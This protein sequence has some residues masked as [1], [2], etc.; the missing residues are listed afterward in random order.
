MCVYGLSVHIKLTWAPF[1]KPTQ[2]LQWILD[3][4]SFIL[5]LQKHQ[6][7]LNVSVSGAL[8]QSCPLVGQHVSKSI[9][10]LFCSPAGL[11]VPAAHADPA[12]KKTAVIFLLLMDEFI[13][14]IY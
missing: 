14:N 13:M 10:V 5:Y 9:K 1:S 3:I 11:S 12:E 7:L 6:V 2:L 4:Q 8:E